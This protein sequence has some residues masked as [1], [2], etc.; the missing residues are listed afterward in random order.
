MFN[1]SYLVCD[2]AKAIYGSLPHLN[3]S[4]DIL[5]PSLGLKKL[6]FFERLARKFLGKHPETH[7]KTNVREFFKLHGKEIQKDLHDGLISSE[8]VECSKSAFYQAI[9]TQCGKRDH[10]SRDLA[11]RACVMIDKAFQKGAFRS[12]HREWLFQQSFQ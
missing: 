10:A 11:A 8:G 5:L 7:L 9:L 4:Q 2:A 1:K 6:D 3:D 12:A